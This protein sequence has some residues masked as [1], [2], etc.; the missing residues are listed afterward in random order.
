M[1][2]ILTTFLISI[3]MLAGI[4]APSLAYASDTASKAEICQ[5]VGVVSGT[6]NC[7]PLSTSRSSINSIL[8][9]VL[10]LF[11]AIVGFIAVI[12]ILIAGT[13]YVISS[14][15]SERTNEAKNTILY[16]VIGLLIVALAQIIVRFVLKKVGLL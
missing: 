8:A 9:L 14:G 2:N 15:N 10:N 5:G 3:L 16:A 7:N 6:N 11:S 12:M 4:I 1:K 13:K